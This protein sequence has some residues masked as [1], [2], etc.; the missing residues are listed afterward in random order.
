[1]S[2]PKKKAPPRPAKIP[3]NKGGRARAAMTKVA[4]APSTRDRGRQPGATRQ[5]SE[6]ER[7]PGR[8]RYA[9]QRTQNDAR[10]G[11]N[12]VA[13]ETAT[14]RVQA[15]VV[16]G[17]ESAA[18]AIAARNTGK[19]IALS[20][21]RTKY[22]E[23]LDSWTSVLSPATKAKYQQAM[24]LFAKYLTRR[25][26]REIDPEGGAV[27]ELVRLGK[28]DATL[29]VRS[30]A[31]DMNKKGDS[32]RT[33]AW[34]VSALRSIFALAEQLEIVPWTLHVRIRGDDE[35]SARGMAAEDAQ[36]QWKRLRGHL[37]ASDL[38]DD[39]R[40]LAILRLMHDNGL[41]RFEVAGLERDHIDLRSS[42]AWILGKGKK[43]RRPVTL[44][45]TT[46]AAI[47][48][49][50]E[51]RE[52]KSSASSGRV[53][54]CSSGI[55]AMLARRCRQL[56]LELRPH[57]LRRLA[58]TRLLELTHGDVAKVQQFSRHANVKT[59]MIYDKRRRDVAGELAALVADD[60]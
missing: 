11:P 33:V 6:S 14:A 18:L 49:W 52:R 39:V 19:A 17:G 55:S 58:I 32:H 43:E 47:A 1:V 46:A 54:L 36:K 35:P 38:A 15:E 23:L 8:R 48:K 22:E 56:G 26:G 21:A 10:R 16:T 4:A 51:L 40:D 44:A 13:G 25:L 31:G 37:S 27:G 5:R 60:E 7:L 3:P 34:R 9:D 28:A 53:F 20:R 24:A 30:W 45:K 59:V 42:R 12:R 29:L 41:R 50:I 2:K 57:D